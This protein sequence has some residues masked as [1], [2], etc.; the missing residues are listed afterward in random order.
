MKTLQEIERYTNFYFITDIVPR[1]PDSGFSLYFGN[2]GAS[3]IF[4]TGIGFYGKSGM[5]FDS[6]NNFFGGYYSGRQIEIEGHFFNGRLSY[7]CDG[8]LMANNITYTGNFNCIE[9][10]KL[11]DSSLSMQI[12]YI[13]GKIP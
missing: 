6:Q 3:Q 8:E 13:S 4:S 11:G 9:F 1:V 12:N 2:T 5:V 7:F 10:N